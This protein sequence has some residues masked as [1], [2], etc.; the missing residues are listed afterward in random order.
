MAVK[1]SLRSIL[2]SYA[3]L[4]ALNSNFEKISTAIDNTLSRD[5]TGPNQ[6][7]AGLNMNGY[8]ISNTAEGVLP[9]DLANLGQVQDVF[10]SYNVEFR[11]FNSYIQ[12]RR[13]GMVDWVNL[14]P[15]SS[16]TGPQGVQGPAGDQGIQ[17]PQG[18]AG[19]GLTNRGNWVSGTSYV[20]NDFVFAVNSSGNQSL[21]VNRL[22]T[23]GTTQPKDTPA[24]WV[25]G[26]TL[27]VLTGSSGV[28]VSA[29]NATLTTIPTGRVL[30]NAT[31]STAAPT[32]QTIPT[33]LGYTPFNAAGGT[34]TGNTLLLR[35]TSDSFFT[36]SA[37]QGYQ[38]GLVLTTAGSTRWIM[39]SSETAGNDFRILRY[40]AGTLQDETFT[41]KNSTGKAKTGSNTSWVSM[42]PSTQD[43]SQ[44]QSVSPD[45]YS[46][47]LGYTRVS[48]NTTSGGSQGS[49][50]VGGF[51]YQDK[52]LSGGI[53]YY[54]GY[55]GYFEGRRAAG[56]G[57]VNTVE[58][59]SK[60]S[61]DVKLVT[62]YQIEDGHVVGL[63]LSTLNANNVSAGLHIIGGLADGN[64][65]YVSGIVFDHGSCTSNVALW[66]AAE[67]RIVFSNE[68]GVLG[69]ITATRLGVPG[70]GT[71]QEL[72]VNKVAIG[73]VLKTL[74]VD[75]S[76]FVKAS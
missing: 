38:K 51:V 54:D 1:I 47:F 32:A 60:N 25:E 30:G 63:K 16:I 22:A 43:T 10:D 3:S 55:A 73:G 9:T 57:N 64:S 4:S 31:G 70:A 27:P 6:M 7:S 33:I 5:G 20:S 61:G 56:A 13:V 8:P 58:I 40:N 34:I 49:Y 72:W 75:G 46:A 2:S 42:F 52:A 74:S 17:G 45:G 39:G 62:P 48:D 67:H 69:E 15:F 66:M 24:N 59:A 29:N 18:T 35:T 37:D 19:V 14:V 68:S 36:L 21:F 71:F 28:T 12:Y 26:I 44:L 11:I 41:I 23:S 65:Q 53:S 50:A 76:G